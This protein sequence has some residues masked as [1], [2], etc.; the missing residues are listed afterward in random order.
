M[1]HGDYCSNKVVSGNAYCSDVCR[2][3]AE[4]ELPAYKDVMYIQKRL[5][6]IQAMEKTYRYQFK[7]LRKDPSES[8]L[9]RL[10]NMKEL[11]D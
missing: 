6:A 10:S 9:A 8:V 2:K 11:L 5:V 7:R 3:N 4:I 1:C